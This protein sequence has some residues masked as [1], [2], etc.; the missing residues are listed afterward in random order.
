MV[1]T[2]PNTM[3]VAIHVYC[4]TWTVERDRSSRG[5][6]L[7]T[8]SSIRHT[9]RLFTSSWWEGKRGER[10]KEGERGGGERG[11][12]EREGGEVDVF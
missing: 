12:E 7:F 6:S 10:G 2:T 3:Y 11:G 9:L 8:L 5:T 1:N 4:Y